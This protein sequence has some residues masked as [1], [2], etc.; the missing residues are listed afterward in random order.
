MLLKIREK[1]L[2]V[3]VL[4]D[5]KKN[6]LIFSKRRGALDP[7]KKKKLDEAIVK[8]AIT[9]KKNFSD[10]ENHFCRQVLFV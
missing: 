5:Q 8:M 4:Q 9:M 10:V 3:K 7:F 1:L 6:I 2:K